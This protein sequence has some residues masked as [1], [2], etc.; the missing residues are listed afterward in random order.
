MPGEFDPCGD[1]KAEVREWVGGGR[2][3]LW[4]RVEGRRRTQM[5]SGKQSLDPAVIQDPSLSR[6]QTRVASGYYCLFGSV[7][8]P[9]LCQ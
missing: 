1:L 4:G 5:R 2:E 8:L 3:A 9:D 7:P 6:W